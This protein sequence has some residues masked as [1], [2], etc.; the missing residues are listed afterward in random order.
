MTWLLAPL[1]TSSSWTIFS[2]CRSSRQKAF[3]V[4][5]G[6]RLPKNWAFSEAGAAIVME[7]SANPTYAVLMMAECSVCVLRKSQDASFLKKSGSFAT[8]MAALRVKEI[9]GSIVCTSS[10]TIW[11]LKR[12][13]MS[14]DVVVTAREVAV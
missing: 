13:T 5:G 11:L 7:P 8:S 3:T 4:W 1:K 6:A 12:L 9:T 14:S 10:L 2:L